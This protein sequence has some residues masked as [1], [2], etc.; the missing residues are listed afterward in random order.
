LYAAI[1]S[2]FLRPPLLN[3]LD[4]AFQ[5]VLFSKFHPMK[6]RYDKTYDATYIDGWITSIY[7]DGINGWEKQEEAIATSRAWHFRRECWT[8]KF[9]GYLDR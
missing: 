9:A 2:V 4:D 1:F 3:N 8:K 7:F 6:N 5:Q